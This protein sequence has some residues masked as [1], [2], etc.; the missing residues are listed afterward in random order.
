MTRVSNIE[1][2]SRSEQPVLSIRTTTKAR[3]LPEL[4]GESYRKI[5]AYLRECGEILA[6]V[7]FVA[8]HNTDMRNID[9]EIGFPISKTLP[10]KEEIMPSFIPGGKVALCMYLGA[11]GDME[12]TYKEM[13]SWVE[14]NGLEAKG[15]A[16]EHYYNGTEFSESKLL[17]RIVMPIE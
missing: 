8:Y 11:H 15:I 3:H 14:E 5:A 1:I 10:G 4:I 16:Y 12:P 17:T 13:A 9:V 2:L 6:D 7:P